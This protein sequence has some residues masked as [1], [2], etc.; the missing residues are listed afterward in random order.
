MH[1]TGLWSFFR[2]E[3]SLVGAQRI[4]LGSLIDRR[5]PKMSVELYLPRLAIVEVRIAQ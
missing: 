5:I 3:E 4:V 1:K 2:M